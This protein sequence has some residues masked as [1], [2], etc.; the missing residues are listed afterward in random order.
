MHVDAQVLTQGAA[1]TIFV[2]SVISLLS[3]TRR[4]RHAIR[5]T[6]WLMMMA[7]AWVALDPLLSWH[8]S[9]W[10]DPVLYVTVALYLLADH[11]LPGSKPTERE[12][13]AQAKRERREAIVG[14]NGLA[15]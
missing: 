7:S 9:P 1:V 10:A 14:H 5:L 15:K 6:V 3:M 2:V 13:E 4:T 8:G 12:R 11:R